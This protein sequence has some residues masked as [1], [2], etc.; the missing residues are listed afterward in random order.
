M[1]K[2]KVIKRQRKISTEKNNNPYK[3]YTDLKDYPKKKKFNGI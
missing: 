1:Y 2:R 3:D